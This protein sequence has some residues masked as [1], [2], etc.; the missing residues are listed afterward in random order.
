MKFTKSEFKNMLKETLVELI[1]E[2]VFDKKFES[3]VE[4]KVKN[5]SVL[6]EASKQPENSKE[7]MIKEFKSKIMQEF[8]GNPYANV[9]SQIAE[10]MPKRLDEEKDSELGL[11]TPMQQLKDQ[12]DLNKLSGGN[13]GRWAA[14]AFSSTRKKP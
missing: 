14:N 8:T 4:S 12:E 3:L 10:E 11:G 1:N 13:I 6:K 2:G 5:V 9:L 7:Q